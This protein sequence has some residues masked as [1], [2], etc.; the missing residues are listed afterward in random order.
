MQRK[1]F[2]VGMLAGLGISAL[3]V[4]SLYLSGRAYQPMN[5]VRPAPFAMPVTLPQQQ[6][7]PKVVPPGWERRRFNGAD[8]YIVPL[9]M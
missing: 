9:G 5:V 7:D 6:I 4:W 1:S 3:A 2:L 8:Y